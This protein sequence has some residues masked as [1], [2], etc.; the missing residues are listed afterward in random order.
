MNVT[1]IGDI[2]GNHII[3][4]HTK[5]FHAQPSEERVKTISQPYGI[6]S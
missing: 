5:K 4:F 2:E 6:V 3:L 1:I